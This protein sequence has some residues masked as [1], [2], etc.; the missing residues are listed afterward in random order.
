MLSS[1]YRTPMRA[2]WIGLVLFATSKL[3][4]AQTVID[5]SKLPQCAVDC[6][7]LNQANTGCVPP[8]AP[9]T[10][11]GIYQS[12]MCQSTF[13]VTLYSTPDG[14]C[15]AECTSSGDRQ[16]LKE[17]YVG[18]CTGGV[19]VTPAGGKPTAT[20][21]GGQSTSTAG[22]PQSTKS[23]VSNAGVSGSGINEPPK[24]WIAG[25]WQYVLM[26]IIIFLA[27]VFFTVL[28]LWLKRRHRRKQD[29]RR[30][31]VAAPDASF[32]TT[33]PNMST[34]SYSHSPRG[35]GLFRNSGGNMTSTSVVGVGGTA[36]SGAM[37]AV[38]RADSRNGMYRHSGG[39]GS[40][41]WGGIG[42][43]RAGTANSS[44]YPPITSPQLMQAQTRG[45]EYP[46]VESDRGQSPPP[47][48]SWSN[49]SRAKARSKEKLGDDAITEVYQGESP[50]RHERKKRDFG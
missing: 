39:A 25:H 42:R 50:V 46:D 27:M 28:G 1:R 23:G 34:I 13:L 14:V 20:T 44:T 45:Y 8:S 36:P 32:V 30:S 41:T 10:D 24:T 31:N 40:G 29:A 16:R 49:T 6:A 18:L 15:D 4:L 17:W 2:V 26:L 11:Q 48:G 12:C 33:N 5:A 22:S 21:K 7:A 43:P 35:S 38:G 9:V 19:V 37:G 3:S 47:H